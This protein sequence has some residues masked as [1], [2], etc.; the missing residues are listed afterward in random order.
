MQLDTVKQFLR[1][2]H[3]DED[4]YLN[5]LIILAKEMCE[6]YL[7]AAMPSELPESMNQAML[8]I[9]GYFY[10]NREGTKEGLPEVVYTLLSPY[11]EVSW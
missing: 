7:R 6:N 8:I 11:R 3:N 10:E 9:I 2:D 4:N 5:I 1:I